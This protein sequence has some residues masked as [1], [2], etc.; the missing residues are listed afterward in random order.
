[1]S[2]FTQGVMEIFDFFGL[3]SRTIFLIQSYFFNNTHFITRIDIKRKNRLLHV[4]H[5]V[6]FHFVVK[7]LTNHNETMKKMVMMTLKIVSKIIKIYLF[8]FGKTKT[9]GRRMKA[10]KEIEMKCKH[11]W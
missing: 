8:S 7:I 6:T 5:D 1:M 3:L 2:S 10:I 11:W 4:V 9:E